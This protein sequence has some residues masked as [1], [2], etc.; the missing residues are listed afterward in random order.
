MDKAFIATN[1]KDELNILK[2][3]SSTP[4]NGVT[5]FPFTNEARAACNYLKELM[6][7]AGLEAHLDNSGALIGRIEGEVKET[8]MIGS[9]FDSVRNGGAYDGI[10]GVVSAIEI[11]RLLKKSGESFKYSLEVIATN[12]EEG[13][14]FN[15]GLFT[16]KVLLGQ[17]SSEALKAQV[18]ADG[19]SV[20]DAMKAYGL[21]PDEIME[22]TRDDIKA[23][24][25][26]H[27]E[28]GPV[29]EAEEKEIGIVDVIVGIKRARIKINGRADHS[30]T[31]PMNMRKDALEQATKIISRI[32]DRARLFRNAVATVGFL[33]VEPNIM[34]IVPETVTF[35]IDIRGVDEE[36]INS[37]YFSLLADLDEM[38]KY[39]GMTYEVENMLYAVPVVMDEAIRKSF[40][41]SCIERNLTY[42]H[43]PSGA[44]H[45]AQIFGAKLPAA[46]LFVPSIG[47]RSHCPEEKSDEHD[48][49]S[50]ALVA[51]DAVRKLLEVKE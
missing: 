34:N 4:G 30:G 3:F 6:E 41:Q 25:E 5:R 23:F 26:I 15:T 35:T 51:Y 22:H 42:M 19:I 24:V 8:I 44:G 11:A 37:Q 2:T 38:T 28:Q 9:H 12:D 49:T 47:G 16:G 7:E 46:M 36:T 18:D 20:Y 31:M 32:G 17:L 27:I 29:L 40:E 10:A 21:K 48:L 50:A 43:L 1:I 45:D 14:R 39:T 13:S 33:K